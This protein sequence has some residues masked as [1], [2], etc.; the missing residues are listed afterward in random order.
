MNEL[1]LKWSAEIFHLRRKNTFLFNLTAVV[2][3]VVAA[4]VVVDAVAVVV[5]VV[6]VVAAAAV[7]V[8]AFMNE[9]KQQQ[10][11][12]RP[13]S[14]FYIRYFSKITFVPHLFLLNGTRIKIPKS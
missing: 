8:A 6:V 13:G 10:K 12:L 1:K 4:V 3:A 9:K 5:V 2:A 14:I 11:I 7:A